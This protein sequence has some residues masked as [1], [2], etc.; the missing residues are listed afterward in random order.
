MKVLE[1]VKFMKL[2]TAGFTSLNFPEKVQKIDR[3][4]H[5]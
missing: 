3:V 5:L 2:K 4:V 1:L